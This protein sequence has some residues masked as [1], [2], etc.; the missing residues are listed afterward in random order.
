MTGY[1]AITILFV[2]FRVRS[3]SLASHYCV[4]DDTN[5]PSNYINWYLKGVK[6]GI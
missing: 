2:S 1:L 5:P 6:D 4:S 3:H